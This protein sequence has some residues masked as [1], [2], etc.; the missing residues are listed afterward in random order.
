[1]PR[2]DVEWKELIDAAEARYQAMT[3]EQQEAMW[4][5]Q[6]ESFV[7]GMA[8]CEH[9]IADFEDCPDCRAKYR[10]PSHAPS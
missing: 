8:P 9:G 3:P 4:K 2:T 10:S 6:R 1:M 5:A 7:R